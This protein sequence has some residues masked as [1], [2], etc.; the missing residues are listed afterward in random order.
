MSERKDGIGW[1]WKDCIL[2]HRL[3]SED[4]AEVAYGHELAAL[5]LDR[6]RLERWLAQNRRSNEILNTIFGEDSASGAMPTTRE[7]FDAHIERIDAEM[8]EENK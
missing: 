7:E 2:D 5:R 3:E 8:R 6:K 4:A 1:V